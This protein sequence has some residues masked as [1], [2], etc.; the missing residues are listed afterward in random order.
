MI[1]KLGAQINSTSFASPVNFISG[2]TQSSNPY[3][4]AVGDLDGDGRAD[5]VIP[6]RAESYITVYRNT[7]TPGQISTSSLSTKTDIACLFGPLRISIADLDA[8]GKLD[9]VVFYVS[10]SPAQPYFS[11][12]RNISS[13]GTITF[14]TRQ[15]FSVPDGGN[16]ALSDLDGDGKLD[17][18]SASYWGNV[19]YICRNT[20]LSPGA[21]SFSSAQSLATAGGPAFIVSKDFDGD[22]KRDIAVANYSGTG[23]NTVYVYRN[24]GTVIG[25]ISMSSPLI[26]ATGSLPNGLISADI[27]GDSKFDLIAANYNSGTLSVYRNTSTIGTL[28]FSTQVTFATTGTQGPQ[29]MGVADFDNDGKIDLVVGNTNSTNNVSV[30]RNTSTLGQITS[31]SFAARV[32]FSTGAG[33]AATVGDIDND[34]NIDIISS[35][36]ST[37]TISILRNQCIAAQ[38]T[39]SAG[40]ITFSNIA[41]NSMTV[42]IAKGNGSRR[43]VICK[44]GS[45]VNSTPVT[46]NG[47]SAN[48]VFGNGSM[49]GVGNYVVFADTGSTFNLSGL[50]SNTTYYFSVF[51]F[52][53]N[54]TSS[55]YLT[56]SFLTGSQSTLNVLY[57]YSKPTGNL[58]V[59]SSWG[60]NLNGTGTSPTSF[61]TSNSYYFV[62]NNPSPTIGA[63]ITISGGNTALI[64]GDGNNAVNFT[65]PSSL[66]VNTESLIAKK[67]STLTVSGFLASPS[68][69]FEDSTTVQYLGNTIQNIVAGSYYNIVAGLSAK[70]LGSGNAEARNSLVLIASI[71]LN[72]NSF[73]IGTST[74]QTGTLNYVSGIMYGGSVL[75]WFAPNANIGTTGLF[76][77]GTLSNY[78][79]VQINYTTAPS[80]GGLLA[81]S[82]NSAVPNNL[83]LP[84]YDFTTSPL[85]LVN[86]VGKNGTWSLNPSGITGGQFSVSI[87]A[88]GF[89]GITSY[90][91]LR[92]VRRNNSTSAWTISGTATITTGSNSSPVLYRTGMNL[93]GEF[94]VGADSN[95][96]SLPVKL[97]KFSALRSGNDVRLSWQTASEQNNSHF[98]IERSLDGDLYENIGKLDGKGNSNKLS[99]YNFVDEFVFNN[100][101]KT[102]YYRLKQF[103][104]DGNSEHFV[105]ILIYNFDD[106]DILSNVEVY[107]NPFTNSIYIDFVTSKCIEVNLEIFDAQGKRLKSELMVSQKGSNR[108]NLTCTD[109]LKPGF[110]IFNITAGGKTINQKVVKCVN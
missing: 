80:T 106:K 71:N 107:P 41:N 60:T 96:N 5:I 68:N 93:F 43:I 54:S 53:G 90:A 102:V 84:V 86:K 17:V 52:N 76:P 95:Q 38:P 77:I 75:R 37:N 45:S 20:T 67:N 104:L 92:M 28:S 22:N 10:I 33:A 56:S 62:Q 87:T 103:D 39:I 47:Y 65:I 4:T 98:E 51:E 70:V 1:T 58:D 66:V 57:Y 101:I 40:A 110:Y 19:M 83:G 44:Q 64:I 97:V 11:V 49:L 31:S 35:N 79:P 46:G 23:A 69:L 25:T 24:T 48:S 72:N 91:D 100:T 88:N 12:Y 15:D 108:S 89:Y 59:L 109:S 63:N 3:W 32:D 14:A 50:I 82:F 30:F 2:T 78:L 42:S 18:M 29:E 27:D 61:N 73:T 36:G 85:V 16:G 6:N 8:D 13:P 34:G 55:N 94:G 99:M 81:A 105:P 7:S 74:T 26:L 21:I 9:V